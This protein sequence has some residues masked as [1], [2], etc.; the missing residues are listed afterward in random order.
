MDVRNCPM[1]QAMQLPDCCFG[2]REV[3]QL[4]HDLSDANAVYVI[5]PAGLS[6]R[7]VIW[8][9]TGAARGAVGVTVHVGLVLGDQLPA[10]DA[11]YDALELVFP[12]VIDSTGVR[13]SFEVA[14]GSG[15]HLNRLRLP[16]YTAGRRF[17]ARLVRHQGNATEGI[18]TVTYSSMP[19]EVPYWL[20]LAKASY[21][22]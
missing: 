4:A 21:P 11:A 3:V 6:E 9:V 17:V 18:I 7:S 14:R 20:N 10:S 12:N 8:E 15:L 16:L 13:S 19:T 2:R 1:N 22:W 5:S